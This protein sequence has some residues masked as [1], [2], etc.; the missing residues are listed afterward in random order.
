MARPQNLVF[1]PDAL[2]RVN[3]VYGGRKFFPWMTIRRGPV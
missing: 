2:I 1:T 3:M